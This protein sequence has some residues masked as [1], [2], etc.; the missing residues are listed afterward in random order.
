MKNILAII[1]VSSRCTVTISK[2]LVLG[3]ITFTYFLSLSCGIATA[4]DSSSSSSP[5]ASYKLIQ[6]Q[7][8]HRH[9]DRTPL[10]PMKDKEFWSQTLPTKDVIEKIKAGTTI[11]RDGE[12]FSHAAVGTMPFG[13]LTQMGL[14]QMVQVGS[15]VRDEFLLSGNEEYRNEETGTLHRL[16]TQL[17][18]PQNPLMPSNVKVISTDFPRTIQS[19]QGL[20]IGLFP[21]GIEAPIDIDVRHTKHLI[22]DP[23]P[24]LTQKQVELELLLSQRTHVQKKHE[25]LRNL[26]EKVTNSLKDM[27]ALDSLHNSKYGVGEDDDSKSKRAPLLSTSQ[28][29]EIATCL[30]VRNLLPSS[31][32]ETDYESIVSFAAFKWFELMRN[33]QL[34][35]LA[36][37]TFV[38]FI[39]DNLQH[40]YRSANEPLLHV[41]SCHDS[42]LIGLICA[43]RLEQ[44]VEWPEYGSY[45]KIELFVLDNT[46]DNDENCSSTI[47]QKHYLRFSLNG[48]VLKS[49]WGVG[50]ETYKK[51]KE[52]IPLNHLIAAIEREH[53]INEV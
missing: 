3:F 27:I 53:G 50:D 34:S 17:F 30:K 33:T 28:M 1:T 4:V 20:L 45:L 47:E 37:K 36:T 32:S 6:V 8:V 11:L 40:H 9:G 7:I 12:K 41:F 48:N 5:S 10:T 13:Q 24:R 25:E 35:K 31:I 42:S 29:A 21:D 18:T 26:S 14:L 23:Q 19:V 38:D 15:K 22:P 51:P 43:F 49:S 2:A 44:P 46:E 52:L 16:E 39:M